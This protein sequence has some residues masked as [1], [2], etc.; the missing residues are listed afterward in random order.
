MTMVLRRHTRMPVLLIV[1]LLLA[2][3]LARGAS[4]A[5]GIDPVDNYCSR[6][7]HQST[8]KNRTLYIDGGLEVFVEK[9]NNGT[10][11]GAR[12]F[13]Y[14]T[15][16]I[17][18]DLTSSWDWKRNISIRATSK[19]PN[20]RT[21]AD[22]PVVV[23]GA[24]YAGGPSDSSIYQYGGTVSYTNT[25]FPGFQN[26][27]S[28]EYALWSYNT[29][30]GSWDQFDV[31]LGA[32][33]RP[34]GGA[35][36]EAPDQELAFYLNGYINNGTSN[37]LEDS[38]DL[39]RYLDGL[40]VI[41]THT[42]MATNIS[43]SSL[44][45]FP[46]V[47][48]G[49][50]YIPGIGPKGILVAVGG[51][52]KSASDGSASNEGTYVPFDEID[53]FDISSVFEGDDNGIWYAQKA[54][55]DIPA[56]R[57]DFCL[58][59]VSAKDNSS[60][61]IYMYG[62]KGANELYDEIY[63][64][65]IPSFTWTKISEGKSPRYGHT[66]HLV[67]N[68][69]MLTVGGASSDDLSTCDWEYRGVAIYDMSTSTWGSVYDAFAADYAVPAKVYQ[70]IGGGPNG[71]ATKK[72]PSDGFSTPEL[73]SFFYPPANN[74]S[75]N[76]QQSASN[77]LSKGAIAGIA[78]GSVA[79]AAILSAALL[80]TR[81]RQHAAAE[82]QRAAEAEEAEKEIFTETA[83]RN[84]GDRVESLELGSSANR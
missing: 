51:V 59:A 77:K 75:A 72:T 17:E 80:Y 40:I 18:V 31:T 11:E 13:G 3:S 45:N 74:D 43:T 34:A 30:N 76:A 69:Q 4:N 46:R 8:V 57:T 78:V 44:A 16:L 42:Q 9:N 14:N 67:A 54:S 66:C 15:G 64:L 48:G 24:L 49:M 84:N 60:H 6:V 10:A 82:A 39:L 32:E 71:N 36:G 73:A 7:Y 26:P 56:G 2:V 21:G 41:D 70:V 12:V 79:G 65:S 52:T 68:R 5:T 35:Y 55:G 62:G 61:N 38:D 37:D 47:R 81:Q 58:V 83:W 23:R 1:I 29:S 22:P 33:Y 20:P 25:S 28:S 27:T 19:R 63:V 50:V 53:I